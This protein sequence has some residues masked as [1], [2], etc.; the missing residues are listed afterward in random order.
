MAA[1]RLCRAEQSLKW[2]SL[3]KEVHPRLPPGTAAQPRRSTRPHT[4]RP[5]TW[6]TGCSRPLHSDTSEVS[7]VR[8]NSGSSCCNWP[9]RPGEPPLYTEQGSWARSPG[10]SSAVHNSDST[11]RNRFVCWPLTR[12]S[13]TL[14]L[15]LVQ[16]VPPI[17]TQTVGLTVGGQDDVSLPAGVLNFSNLPLEALTEL[18]DSW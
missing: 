15:A 9:G 12:D 16:R 1:V 5:R 17:L 13:P 7:T 11:L 4:G 18:H 3:P 8:W 14:V 2:P 10:W 6:T